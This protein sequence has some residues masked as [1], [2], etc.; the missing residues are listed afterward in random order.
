MITIKNN[1]GFTL[2]ELMITITVF[3]ILASIGTPL[4]NSFIA[5]NRLTAQTNQMVSSLNLARSES[6]KRSQRATICTSD[7]A[8]T[9]CAATTWETGW[10]VF[11]DNNADNNF[12][13]AD[14]DVLLQVSPSIVGGNT[15]RSTQFV[16]NLFFNPD[17]SAGAA[18]TFRICRQ[19]AIAASAKGV[20]I[21]TA[22]QISLAKNTGGTAAVN[23]YAGVDITCL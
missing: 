4:L 7:V 1:R 17:G 11:V 8:Q 5:S 21:S 10:L 16:N 6:I 12:V 19:D 13:V 9:A 22:G 2:I 15:L 3:A 20:N 14:G 23:D 18:G